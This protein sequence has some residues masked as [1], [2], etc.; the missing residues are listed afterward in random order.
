MNIHWATLPPSIP[1]ELAQP[2]LAEDRSP[3]S[4]TN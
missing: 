4:Q 2:Q 3:L 1:T